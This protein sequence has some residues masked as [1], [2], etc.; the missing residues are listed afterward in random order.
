[1][2]NEIRDAFNSVYADGP[3][4]NPQQPPK[5]RIRAE[6][7]GVI[8]SSIDSLSTRIDE[9]EDV[10]QA[11][12]K[13]D[14]EAVRVLITTNTAYS[15]IT[16]GA[17]IDGVVLAAGDRVGRAYNGAA[18]NALNGVV[19]VQASGA[20]VRAADFDSSDEI[21]RSRFTVSEGTHAG[22]AWSVQNTSAI[23]VGTTAITI[24]M[25]TPSNPTSAEVVGARGG[26]ASLNDNLLAI[27]ARISP[28]VEG[29]Q[30]YNAS[31]PV[32]I[33]SYP[34]DRYLPSGAI[35]KHL[36]AETTH[37]G[38]DAA[39][40]FQIMIGGDLAYGPEEVE[41]GTPL[42]ADD[43]SIEAERGDDVRLEIF[44]VAGGATGFW[45]QM[46]GVAA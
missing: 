44:S 14:K 33:G 29:L 1:M 41:I 4:G 37:G 11:G 39:V 17:E 26:E 12:I 34:L 21:L 45:F 16:A 46:D 10:A 23:T 19:V 25:T 42:N 3:I 32:P 40:A 2:A 15:A 22:E 9:V 6:V 38:A 27:I 18:G 28:V 30:I 20:A 24:A 31:D 5:S 8:Q 7:G 36:R 13:P 43:L 35:F